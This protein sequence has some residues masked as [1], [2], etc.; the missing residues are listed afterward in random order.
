VADRVG[1]VRRGRAAHV[2]D[3]VRQPPLVEEDDRRAVLLEANDLLG[4]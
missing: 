1:H 3:L 2:D 4:V